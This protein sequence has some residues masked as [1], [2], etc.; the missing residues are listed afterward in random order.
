[1]NK[2]E[3]LERNKKSNIDREDEME[4][5]IEGKAGMNAKL[6]FSAIVVILVLFKNY[7]HMPTGDIWAI[8]TAYGAT[9]SFYKYYYLKHKKLLISGILFSV[10]SMCSLLQFFIMTSR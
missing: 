7:K 4:Q 6:V 2:E 9:E 3:I 1:M 10:A 8:F 5:Y